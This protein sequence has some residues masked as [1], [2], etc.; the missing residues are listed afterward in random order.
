MSYFRKFGVYKVVPRS[1][2]KTTGGKVIGTRWVDVN[3]GDAENP[4]CRSRLVG[5]EFNVGRD[6][7]LYAA[8]PPL[9]A[10]RVV[11]SHAATHDRG[12][13]GQRRNVMINDVRRAYF[14]AKA[15]RDLYI[16][17]PKEDPEAAPD[18]LGKLELCLYGTRDAA[19]GWQ[20]TLSEQLEACGFKRGVGHPSVFW[21]EARDLMTL[22]HGDDYVTSG[23][24]EQLD[25]L[26][27]QLK[28]AYEIQTQRLGMGPQCEAEGKV[29]NRIV[30]CDAG[31]WRL[32]ADPR[33]A[34]L[35]VE[36]LG[37]GE[38]R[39]AATPGIDGPE[40]IDQD[41]DEDI[42][43][44]DV[45]RFRGVAARCNYLAFDRPDIQFATK[46]I[47]RE[48]SKPTTGS[49][50]RLKRLGQYL[51]GR[52]RLVWNFDMQEEKGTI[53]VFSDSDWAGCRKSRKSTS[54]WTIMVGNHCLKTWSK[55]QAIIA[56]SS[57]EAEL[58]GVVRGATEALGMCSLMGDLGRNMFIRMGIDAAAAKGILERRGLSKVRHI[59]VNILWLQ[60]V[61]ARKQ[62]PVDKVPGEEN[63]A[64]LATKHLT[65]K[66]IDQNIQRM[67]MKFQ[68]GRAAKAAQLHSMSRKQDVGHDNLAYTNAEIDRAMSSIG[69]KE[70]KS[71]GLIRTAAN[72]ARG[73]DRWKTRGAGGIWHRWHV[74]PR[75]TLFTPFRVSKGPSKD[76]PI[77]KGR[78]TVGVTNE[79]EHFEIVDDWSRPENSHKNMQKPWIGYTMFAEDCEGAEDL[80]QSRTK[81]SWTQPRVKWAD[82]CE[83]E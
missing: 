26:E 6:D 82:Q 30:R 71:W 13:S 39:A 53:D 9:E 15:T 18:K 23:Q 81:F 69:N 1:H 61:C 65:S 7:T 12:K 83:S 55:T 24:D 5:R 45:T 31:G 73:G 28:A 56:K 3:K 58:Y 10:L 68:E 38:L 8:T 21:H 51:K 75:R 78:L 43:G 25:W 62:I 17:L 42:T 67:S 46:E 44:A 37:V 14:Y 54:G 22:V 11:I 74:T 48:M 36:Q 59:D 79:G 66:W 49:L 63:P 76:V 50:R 72:D 57:A 52:P 80:H 70:I 20:D 60:E 77:K 2:Q 32:E 47:C 19:K 35:V 16:E 40:E 29:L 27:E 4:N 34:E 64:D 33:H 41:D